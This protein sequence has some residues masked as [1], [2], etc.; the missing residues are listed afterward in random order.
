MAH[1]FSFKK[2]LDITSH[3]DAHEKAFKLLQTVLK[4]QKKIAKTNSNVNRETFALKLD[5]ETSDGFSRLN[6][7]PPSP[8]MSFLKRYKN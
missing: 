6:I 7:P 1:V 4:M 2:I 5:L 8:L 3:L